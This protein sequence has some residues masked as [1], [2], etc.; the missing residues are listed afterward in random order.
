MTDNIT[1]YV[2]SSCLQQAEDIGKNLY[3]QNKN[4]QMMTNCFEHPEFRKFFDT[5]FVD[6]NDIKIMFMFISLY[7]EIEKKSP[8]KLNGYQKISIL[9]N[10]I[11][12]S[13]YRHQICQ[14]INKINSKQIKNDK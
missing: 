11:K 4:Y 2:P 8:V 7:R 6:E 14:N 13:N 5:Y 9:D 12:N 3:K 10:I 1:L